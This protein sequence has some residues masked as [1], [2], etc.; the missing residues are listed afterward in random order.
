[1]IFREAVDAY[2][3]SVV[4]ALMSAVAAGGI[5]HRI[6]WRDSSLTHAAKAGSLKT[7]NSFL[8]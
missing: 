3:T 2:A 8:T 5:R 6:A 7:A 4:T 1:M